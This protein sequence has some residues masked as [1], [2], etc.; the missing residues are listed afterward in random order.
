[1]PD[2]RARAEL[3]VELDLQRPCRREENLGP[4]PTRVPQL[5]SACSCGC[6]LP[7]VIF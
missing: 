2:L 4:R 6:H 7:R 5:G 3:A 1:M